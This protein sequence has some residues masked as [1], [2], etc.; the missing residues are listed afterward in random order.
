MQEAMPS[1]DMRS[2]LPVMTYEDAMSSIAS[3][4]AVD[5]RF[6][7][8]PSQLNFASGAG[9]MAYEQSTMEMQPQGFNQTTKGP[10]A[11]SSREIPWH[12][13]S[14]ALWVIVALLGVLIVIAIVS[15]ATRGSHSR[16]H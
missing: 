10:H 9:Q 13:I 6:A 3:R 15:L 5:R 14:M 4:H 16:M 7:A 11:I 12:Q 8:A 2:E 1:W